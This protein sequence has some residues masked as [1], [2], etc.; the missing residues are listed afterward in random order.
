MRRALGKGLSQ[1][2]AEQFEGTP[3]EV[4]LDDIVPNQ[5]QPRTFF[6]ESALEE[7]AA[8]IRDY[9]VLQPLLVK[10]L[11]EGKYELIA[12]ERRL[13]A[14]KLAGL[15]TVPVLV[16]SAGPQ[17][18]L[19]IA[20][21]ENVQREDINALECARA[22]RRLIE[23]F[24]LTQE[25]VAERV[26]KSR[27]TI[28]NTVRLLKLPRRI[29]EGLE[30]NRITEGHARALLAFETEPQQLAIYDQILDRGLTVREVER[31]AKPAGT[32]KA[33]K[34]AEPKPAEADPNDGSLE[35]GLSVFLGTPVRLQRSE[36]GG[37][38]VVEFYSDDDLDRILEQLG[39]R[40]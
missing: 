17:N 1:L 5:R 34:T 21:I 28:A 23:E 14:S 24:D 3:N 37:K 6:D 27:T 2:I 16:R 13:R 12:G 32:K 11:T 31:A 33:P 8:S 25:Q 26:G 22:Y 4:A 18:S 36:V 9:G 29:Q 10:P 39:F 38:L 30:A 19:E 40:L 20:L 7:L 15:K 35:E